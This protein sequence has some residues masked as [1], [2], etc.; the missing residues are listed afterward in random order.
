MIKTADIHPHGKPMVFRLGN[1][2]EHKLV[3]CNRILDPKLEDVLHKFIEQHL[4]ELFRLKLVDSE[5]RLVGGRKSRRPDTL[6]FDEKK[7]CFV[8]VEY[9][10]NERD[11]GGSQLLAYASHMTRPESQKKMLEA[12]NKT[13]LK[14]INPNWTDTYCIYIDFEIS[15]NLKDGT[16]RLR[17]ILRMYEIQLYDGI[18]VLQRVG[19]TKSSKDD[20]LAEVMDAPTAKTQDQTPTDTSVSS[21]D[22][23]PGGVPIIDLGSNETQKYLPHAL[24]FPDG[25]SVEKLKGW[26]TVLLKVAD[27]LDKNGHIKDASQSRLLNTHKVSR[28]YR[29]LRDNLY[30][31]VNFNAKNALSKTKVF[32]GDIDYQPDGFKLTLKPRPSGK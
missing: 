26:G 17:D 16:T 27:W 31:N 24:Q 12:I 19:V 28:G 5:F 18:V 14:G 8:I 13:D 32:L 23:L 2:I 3:Q 4:Y 11:D 6:A 1:P 9:K 7:N 15:E 29:E 25:T 30:I 10:R 22:P 20:G 21:I